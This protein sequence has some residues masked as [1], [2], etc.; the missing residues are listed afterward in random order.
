MNLLLGYYIPYRHMTPLWEMENDYY[1]HNL[2]VKF[3]RGTMPSMKTYQRAFGVDWSDNEVEQHPEK[4]PA[5]LTP[6]AA[7]RAKLDRIRSIRRGTSSSKKDNTTSDCDFHESW[8]ISRVRRRCNAQNEA[9]AVWWKE[10]IQSNI[11]QRMWMQLGN[12]PFEFMLPPRFERAYQPDKLAQ[13]DRFFARVWATPVRRSHSA[14]V[15][16][17]YES[18][19]SDFRKSIS[20]RMAIDN[21]RD[22]DKK[23]QKYLQDVL[24]FT[25]TFGYKPAIYPT[26]VRFLEPHRAKATMKKDRRFVGSLAPEESPDDE[27]IRYVS[28]TSNISS[29]RCRQETYNEFKRCLHDTTLTSDDVGGIKKVSTMIWNRIRSCG[30][31]FDQSLTD[32]HIYIV[33]GRVRFY[34]EN[35]QD[36]SLQRTIRECISN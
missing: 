1:L 16:T 10:A 35:H 11:Q 5:P 13:F 4:E 18:E 23:E 29:H 32:P 36:W 26:L 33:A 6:N 2:H 34:W 8:R 14:S 24:S 7:R 19:L 22:V 15:G 21:L 12:N 3:G 28:P 25:E 31:V 20:G 17:E 30:V 27:Y 9:L